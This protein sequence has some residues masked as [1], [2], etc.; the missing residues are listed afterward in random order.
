MQIQFLNAHDFAIDENGKFTRSGIW[1]LSTDEATGNITRSAEDWA[2]SVGEPWRIPDAAGTAYTLDSKLKI[3]KIECK[4]LDSRHCQVKFTAA[5]TGSSTEQPGTDVIAGSF[6]FERKNDLTEY[7]TISYRLP[8]N[9]LA[10]LPEI[11][12]MID[13]AGSDYRCEEVLAEEKSDNICI[14]KVRAVNI[15]IAPEGRIQSEQRHD[16]EF[17]I[18]SWLIMPEALEKF[19]LDNTLHKTAAWAGENFYIYNVATRPADSAKRTL[20]TLTARRSKLEMIEALRSEE[21]VSMALNTPNT[22]LIWQS[23]WRA[24][25]DDRE[26]FENLLGNTANAWTNDDRAIVS[27]ITPKRVSDCEFEYIVEARHP[28]DIGREYKYDAK[29]LDLPDRHEYYARIGEMRLSAG[30]CGYTWRHNGTYRLIN[31]WQSSQLCPLST[32]VALAQYWINQPVKLLEIVEVSYLSGTSAKNISSIVSWFTN[33]RVITT[34]I[35]GISG[36][37]LRYDLDVDDITDSYDRE[38]TRIK[39]VYR[40]SPDAHTWNSTYWI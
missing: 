13:W 27:K 10:L 18:G 39:K 32:T 25:A 36:C 14:A 38:W 4:A 28:E 1:L 19:L 9:D 16:E 20:V 21:I 35:A 24:T 34:T 26:I 3:S 29:D 5:A 15:A 17:K 40:K 33:S 7:K 8:E 22:R 30:Q 12:S 31:N 11:G 37:F 2:G 6:K 23:R